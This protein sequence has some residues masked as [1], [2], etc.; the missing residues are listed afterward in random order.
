MKF[1]QQQIDE[2]VKDLVAALLGMA[3][4]GAG[5]KYSIDQFKASQEPIEVKVQAA[6]Q[7]KKIS[8]SPE[9]DRAMTAILKQYKPEYKPKEEA[10]K[11]EPA[12]LVKPNKTYD[13]S[14]EPSVDEYSAYII[15]SEIYGDDLSDP[16]NKKFLS[17]YKDDVGLWT[18]GIGHLIGKG[19]YNDMIKF[20][21]QNGRTITIRQLLNMFNKDVE[22]HIKIAKNK[23]GKQWDDF[24]PDLKKAL[25]D[26]SFRGDLLKPN[27]RDDF[28]FVKQIKLGDFKKAAISYLDHTEYKARKSKGGADGVVKRMNRNAR[29]IADEKPNTFD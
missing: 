7:A 5:I 11:R 2:G 8:K 10:P 17:P 27:S 4:S 22:K 13:L 19:S 24:S 25:V 16:S 9:F 12:I 23:F 1:T 18:I 28:N 15:P 20:V 6:E 14:N 29:Y 3:A 26:I 21:E